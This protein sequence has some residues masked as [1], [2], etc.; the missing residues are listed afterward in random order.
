MISVLHKIPKPMDEQPSDFNEGFSA[1]GENED[2]K[3]W[4]KKWKV[5]FISFGISSVYTIFA[6]F[7]P[8][9]IILVFFT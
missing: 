9:F 1:L 7:F 8:G 2:E 5:L 3:E 6:F 4:A